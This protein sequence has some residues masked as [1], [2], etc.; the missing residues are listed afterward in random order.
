MYGYVARKLILQTEERLSI[1]GEPRK[2]DDVEKLT[3]RIVVEGYE[4]IDEKDMC[5]FVD[6]MAGLFLKALMEATGLDDCTVGA[7]VRERATDFIPRGC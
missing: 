2:D 6:D 5:E 1:D 4:L 3:Q 7:I